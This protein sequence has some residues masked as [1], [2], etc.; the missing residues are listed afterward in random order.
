MGRFQIILHP[1][2]LDDGIGLAIA[3]IT[4][5]EYSSNMSTLLEQSLKL[6]VPERIKLVEDIWDSIASDEEAVELTPEQVTELERRI[7]Y[8]RL[9]PNDTIPWEV[10]REEALRR[11]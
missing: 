7:D 3:S 5:C 9:H 10:I 8:H 2:V 1:R 4:L 11:R 6:P